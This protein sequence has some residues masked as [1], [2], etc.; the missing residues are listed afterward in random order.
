MADVVEKA[1]K[2]IALTEE[3]EIH[4]MRSRLAGPG[5]KTCE[6]C[7]GGDTGGRECRRR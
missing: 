7:G 1:M 3:L 6:V 5:R 2:V 4:H